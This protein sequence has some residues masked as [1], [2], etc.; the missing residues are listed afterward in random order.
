MSKSKKKRVPRQSSTIDK[1]KIVEGLVALLHEQPGISIKRNVHLPSTDGEET[2]EIDVLISG[3]LVGYPVQIAIECKNYNREIGKA[4]IDAFIGKLNDLGFPTQHGIYVCTSRYTKGAIKR[5]KNAG[6]KTF[7]LDGLTKDRLS[8]A[9]YDAL[10][11]IIYLL[12]TMASLSFFNDANDAPDMSPQEMGTFVNESSESFIIFDLIWQ[13]WCKRKYPMSI[14][15]HSFEVK[16]PAGYT[17]IYQGKR[18]GSVTV[19]LTL[20]VI[21]LV[22]QIP[23]KA[24]DVQ[25]MNPFTS[26]IEKRNVNISFESESGTLAVNVFQTEESLRIFLESLPQRY[27]LTLGRIAIPRILT[28]GR[29][30]WPPSQ[31]YMDNINRLIKEK[32][33]NINI[34]ELDVLALQGDHILEAAFD[35]IWDGHPASANN[36]KAE[37]NTGT[38]K[39]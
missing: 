21:A 15:K 36:A 3:Q 19:A 17:Q 26:S 4:D 29:V 30:L 13:N 31:R 12:P 1:G 23:G 7:K 6:V 14:G 11:S 16:I 8:A 22:V 25:L 39:N 27:S 28:P 37:A 18:L 33:N 20:E 5:A 38:A 34:Q 2:R 24:Q 10:Q 9:I 35:D 32:G